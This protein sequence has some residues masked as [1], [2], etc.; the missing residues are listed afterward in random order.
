MDN[1]LHKFPSLVFIDIDNKN[2]FGNPFQFVKELYPYLQELPSFV[3]LSSSKKNAYDVIKN[4]FFDYLLKPLSKMELRK[5][6]LKY[7]K[8]KQA[9][10]SDRLC[11]KS[12]S[13]YQF[14]DLDEI[15]YLKADNNTTDFC[16]FQDRKISAYKTLKHFENILP[17]NFLRVHH[18][19][20]I[21]T[22]QITRINFGKSTIVL[23]GKS[24]NIPFS[25]SYK[26][27]VDHLKEQFFSSLSLVS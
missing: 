19:Y 10:R 15:L 11:L 14:V 13:D 9:E 4:D 23:R 5:C 8:Q 2:K 3:A 22:H 16:L 25:K 18:S 17:R 6:L 7:K 20:I 1:I 12:Y 26:P 21:N 27:Q 24:S